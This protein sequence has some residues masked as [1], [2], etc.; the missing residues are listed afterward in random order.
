MA[1]LLEHLCVQVESLQETLRKQQAKHQEGLR[2]ANRRIAGREAGNARLDERRPAPSTVV[3]IDQTAAD[4]A[5]DANAYKYERDEHYVRMRQLDADVLN[6]RLG[7]RRTEDE[8]VERSQALSLA[9]LTEAH[10][11]QRHLGAL[12]QENRSRWQGEASP[13]PSP[14]G[15]AGRAAALSETDAQDGTDAADADGAERTRARRGFWG[16]LSGRMGRR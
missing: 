10:E 15:D 9:S 5:D 16:W 14:N 6:E 12:E 13:H 7:Q 11:L 2:S 8:G 1:D 4:D 3:F